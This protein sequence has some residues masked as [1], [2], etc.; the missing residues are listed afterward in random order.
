[1]L[2]VEPISKTRRAKT[3]IELKDRYPKLIPKNQDF[4]IQ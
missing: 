4:K 2:V 3:K 1:M